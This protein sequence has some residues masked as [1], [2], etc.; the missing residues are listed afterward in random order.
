MAC[1]FETSSAHSG[2]F[3]TLQSCDYEKERGILPHFAIHWTES[4]C[5]SCVFM[6]TVQRLMSFSVLFFVATI[7][8]LENALWDNGKCF[9]GGV[10]K[11]HSL[12]FKP[13]EGAPSG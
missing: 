2:F 5:W 12:A 8:T 3:C 9:E 11:R 13:R 4:Y 7:L 1:L 10:I 6:A